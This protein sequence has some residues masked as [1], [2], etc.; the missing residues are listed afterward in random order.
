MTMICIMYHSLNT[1]RHALDSLEITIQSRCY[2]LLL[3]NTV[4]NGSK[5]HSKISWIYML[6]ITTLCLYLRKQ[7]QALYED[8]EQEV[9][10][11]V[12]KMIDQ[13]RKNEANLRKQLGER[14][15]HWRKTLY[16]L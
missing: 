15:T 3:H 5:M 6:G 12:K 1:S 14:D 13:F 2:F 9:E 4:A 10:E 16:V 8:R 11:F 7:I